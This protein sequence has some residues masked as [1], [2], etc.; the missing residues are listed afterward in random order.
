[1]PRHFLIDSDTAS[2]DAVALIMALRA[3]GVHVVGITTVHGN[4][5]VEQAARNALYTVELC[6]SK[7]PVYIGAAKPL[8]REPQ[9]ATWF[10]GKDGLGDVGYAPAS[11]RAADGDAVDVIL[12]SIST[13][14][15]LELVTLGP[16]TNIALAL[17][18]R[19]S[20]A[21]QL[22]RCV[23]MGGAPCCV[24]N[25]TPAA[26]YNIWTD[27]EAARI[28][29]RSGLPIDLIGWHLCRGS[30]VLNDRDVARAL[31]LDTALARFAIH[32]NGHARKA[33][34][35]QTG[36]DG[37]SLPDPVAMSIALNRGVGTSWSRHHVDVETSS[38][39]TQGMTVIDQLNICLLYTS[40]SPRDGLLSRMPSSA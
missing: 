13:Y 37:I 9:D 24:G 14:P 8:Q 36:E 18:R 33:F 15:D 17:Q 5:G 28:V 12:A 39:L 10:H 2:D 25:V 31:A 11:S 22:K 20:I 1:M 27:P 35:E 29:F 4:V 40:P 26:E 32:C 34:L 38:E 23:V 19:P 3:P 30:A 6:G 21:S 16:L 7:V